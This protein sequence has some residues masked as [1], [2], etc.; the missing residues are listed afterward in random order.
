MRRVEDMDRWAE[1]IEGRRGECER[2]PRTPCIS[3]Y[4][5]GVMEM[6]KMCDGCKRIWRDIKEEGGYGR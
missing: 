4:M 2:D 1:L 3:K 5:T 6:E